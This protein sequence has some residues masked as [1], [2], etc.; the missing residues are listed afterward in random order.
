MLGLWTERLSFQTKSFITTAFKSFKLDRQIMYSNFIIYAKIVNS[1]YVAVLRHYTE[2][3]K[4][5]KKKNYAYKLQKQLK[6]RVFH[7]L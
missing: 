6:A 7:A 5:T 4:K 3:S 1:D 2:F